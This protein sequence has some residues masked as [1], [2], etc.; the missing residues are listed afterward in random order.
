M[1]SVV[2]KITSILS[3]LGSTIIVYLITTKW[4]EQRRTGESLIAYDRLLFMMSVIDVINSFCYFLSSW[5]IP[6]GTPG[7]FGARGTQQTCAAQGFF[8]QL[9]LAIP[10]Y[11]GCLAINY[12]LVINMGWPELRIRGV[13]PWLHIV[14]LLFPFATAVASAAM[15][16]YNNANFWCWIAPLPINCNSLNGPPCIRAADAWIYQWAFFY[17]ELWAMYV[18]FAG[19]LALMFG[20]LA[21]LAV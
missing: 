9:G 5:P 11:N 21:L 12:L 16:L 20:C 3:M 4:R 6:Y 10:F 19:C 2:P 15:G 7:V 8:I 13:E 1:P 14:S 17:A 18:F